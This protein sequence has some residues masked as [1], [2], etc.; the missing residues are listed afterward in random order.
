MENNILILCA[1]TRVELVQYFKETFKGYGKV[2]CSDSSAYAPTLYVADEGFVVPKITDAHYFEEI[3]K[4]CIE[5]QVKA[6][7][8]LIDPE[9]SLLAEHAYL[10]EEKGITVI[11]SEKATV[12]LC[13]DKYATANHLKSIGLPYIPSFISIAEVKKAIEKQEVQFPL[14]QKPKT[15][16][17][18]VGIK[19]INDITELE[20]Y[21]G[22]LYQQFMQG[23]EYG[24]DVFVDMQTGKV[25]DVFIKE[26]LLMR[27]G[28]T[29]KSISRKNETLKSIII[30]FVESLN[31]KGQIDI[32][33]FE[34]AGVFY[35]SEVNPRFGGGYL[36]AYAC[37]MNYPKRILNYLLGNDNDE[38]DYEENVIMMKYLTIITKKEEEL[39]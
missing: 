17:C 20:Q 18:S 26:K 11:V 7:F 32:D 3:L 27:A 36:H 10:F 31:F 13:F 29:D 34:V 6:V 28:E 16:S 21:E 33:V 30:K 19:K 37:G 24:V 15:G 35:I 14:F 5:N 25:K 4:I 22:V 2:F 23:K 39:L 12:D 8:S 38:M 1:G 9:L